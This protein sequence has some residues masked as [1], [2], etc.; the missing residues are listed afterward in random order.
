MRSVWA[1]SSN[2]V[3]VD[4]SALVRRIDVVTPGP[5]RAGTE[6]LVTFDVLG[7]EQRLP[8]EV[9]VYEPPRRY[10]TRNTANNVTGTFEYRLDPEQ[11][12]TRVHLTC[13]VRP[14]GWMWLALPL[15]ISHSRTRF[16][17]QLA[18]LKSAMQ[19]EPR[20]DQAAPEP[21]RT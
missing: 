3:A 14:H 16:R 18:N 13:D 11:Q 1:A 9:W 21:R 5:F 15:L 8:T 6:L 12:G 7:R 4:D 2:S 17:D 20:I 10:G 19:R